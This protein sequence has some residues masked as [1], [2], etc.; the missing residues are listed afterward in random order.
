MNLNSL[1][2]EKDLYN[3]L[4]NL[5][6][7][8]EGNCIVIE[9]IDW[10]ISSKNSSFLSL[11]DTLK[12]VGVQFLT[13]VWTYQNKSIAKGIDKKVY[14]QLKKDNK[15]YTVDEIYDSLME[16]KNLMFQSNSFIGKDQNLI[17]KC[18]D[19]V[20]S[21]GLLKC[22]FSKKP[23]FVKILTEKGYKKAEFTLDLDNFEKITSIISQLTYENKL[24]YFNLE[25]LYWEDIQEVEDKI[26]EFLEKRDL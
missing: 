7:P 2:G 10:P 19:Q 12:V 25:D 5:C 26:N 21:K 9:C 11:S 6:E 17:E 8:N 23:I 22:L 14:F 13:K 1:I 20:I 24:F 16:N 18:F 3:Y 15:I 4:K